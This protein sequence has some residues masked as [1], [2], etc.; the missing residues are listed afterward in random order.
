MLQPNQRLSAFASLFLHLQLLFLS[1]LPTKILP[2][3][4]FVDT[5]QK[6]G[7]SPQK[8]D[9]KIRIYIVSAEKER[10]LNPVR[11]IYYPKEEK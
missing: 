2:L 9:T 8:N 1:L 11:K 6:N 7:K 5:L 4:Q 10:P 3:Y